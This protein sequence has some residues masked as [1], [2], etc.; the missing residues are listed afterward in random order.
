MNKA[1]E[2][3]RPGYRPYP[4]RLESLITVFV[5]QSKGI[6]SMKMAKSHTLTVRK[7]HHT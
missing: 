5:V 7:D 4:R 6:K 3:G 2:T 1:C